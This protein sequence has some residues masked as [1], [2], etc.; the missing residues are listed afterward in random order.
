MLTN[1]IDDL[2]P[3]ARLNAREQALQRGHLER[4]FGIC[5][6]TLQC[7]GQPGKAHRWP[8]CRAAQMKTRAHGH[9]ICYGS[10]S[11]PRSASAPAY[12]KAAKTNLKYSWS[13]VFQRA[14]EGCQQPLTI[15]S[16]WKYYPVAISDPDTGS[17]I[18]KVIRLCNSNAELTVSCHDRGSFRCLFESQG[19]LPPAT[20]DSAARTTM[21]HLVL[22]NKMFNIGI[23]GPEYHY[24]PCLEE[25]FSI[26][27]L[28]CANTKKQGGPSANGR[29]QRQTILSFLKQRFE[30]QSHIDDVARVLLDYHISLIEFIFRGIHAGEKPV[31]FQDIGY[32]G[33]QLLVMMLNNTP[34]VRVKLALEDRFAIL[35]KNYS[36][37]NVI[38]EIRKQRVDPD[39]RELLQVCLGVISSPDFRRM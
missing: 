15:H 34:G 27:L 1:C 33:A 25:L 5:K 31:S 7:V 22:E 35:K 38:T 6:V 20:V 2:L 13:Y 32:F 11:E 12:G 21:L 4:M 39:L 30:S 24:R 37:K 28:M 9:T 29:S 14:R 36:K 16:R 19:T 23:Y 10:Q 17:L 18:S 8:V 3:H 26:V